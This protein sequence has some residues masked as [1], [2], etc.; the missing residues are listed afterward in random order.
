M[1]WC[2][3]FPGGYSSLGYVRTMPLEEA[4]ALYFR[5]LKSDRLMG[6]YKWLIPSTRQDHVDRGTRRVALGL[7]P[8]FAQT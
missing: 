6:I 1:H 7:V 8:R 5:I 3:W 4:L 2:G